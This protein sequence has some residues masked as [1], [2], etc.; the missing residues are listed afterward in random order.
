MDLDLTKIGDKKIVVFDAG[1]PMGLKNKLFDRK[2]ITERHGLASCYLY[3]ECLKKNIQ[4]LTPDLFY[5][6]PQPFPKAILIQNN[7]VTSE[8]NRLVSLGVHPAILLGFEHPLY[9]C[10]F[11]WNL[12]KYTKHFD[13]VFMPTGAKNLSLGGAKFHPWVSPQA[14]SKDEK[15]PSN[16]S[17]KKY[18]TLISGNSRINILKRLYVFVHQII[19][20][21]PTL[22]NR[23]LY[24]DRLKAIQY[25]S[26]RPGFEFYGRG[27]DRPVPRTFG[28]YSKSIERSFKGE[29]VDKMTVLKQYKFSICFENCIFDGW[30][31]EKVIDSLFAGCVPVYLGAPDIT[32]FI[33][34]GAFIDFRDFKSFKDLDE[35]LSN[36]DE[37]TYQGYIENI[38]R[39][40]ASGYSEFSQEK[41][42]S[43]MI[44]LIE[45]YF[46]PV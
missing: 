41:Y 32:D 17:G 18:L 14:F 44:S 5:S 20:P 27:W 46:Q 29:V 24:V 31:T 30:I 13:H 43:D 9:A 28:R 11:Y 10:R 7:T 3:E 39:F 37:K 25:F 2:L 21:L 1:G 8:A 36:M 23:E 38:N 40:I 12:E 42:A 15:I 6:L 4:I 19:K 33:P 16:F 26:S 22:V 35:Y 34:K 45:S